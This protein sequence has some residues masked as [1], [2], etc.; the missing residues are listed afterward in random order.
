MVT[1]SVIRPSLTSRL[2]D[3]EHEAEQLSPLLNDINQSAIAREPPSSANLVPQ[4]S[5]T[6]RKLVTSIE[7]AFEPIQAVEPLLTPAL[8]FNG[9]SSRSTASTITVTT[10]TAVASDTTTVTDGG[11]DNVDVDVDVDV[12]GDGDMDGDGDRGVDSG[13]VRARSGEGST[14]LSD[15]DEDDDSDVHLDA[16]VPFTPIHEIANEVLLR[17]TD[18]SSGDARRYFLR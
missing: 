17:P 7:P 4:R 11:T 15:D 3:L 1:P 9:S 5:R 8:S 14:W 10:S 12:Y 6:F 2:S 13:A 16:T 18:L